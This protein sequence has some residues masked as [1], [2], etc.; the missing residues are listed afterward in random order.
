M[1][2]KKEYLEDIQTREFYDFYR[3]IRRKNSKKI[4]Q[5]NY[6][7][8]AINGMLKEINNLMNETDHGLHL[9]GL[10][11]LYKKP[12]GEYYKKLTLFTHRKVS[13]KRV[14]FYLEDDYLRNRYIITNTRPAI[15]KEDDVRQDKA[16]AVILHRK[17]I[18]KWKN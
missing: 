14:N 13:R 11:V 18:K 2:K 16:T 12:F 9:K 1:I 8:K 4:D 10:G 5:F 3:K 15:K 7:V 17:L 6:F